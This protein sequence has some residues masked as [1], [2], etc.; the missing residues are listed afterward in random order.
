[1]TYRWDLVRG[2][3]FGVL[4]M[5]VQSFAILVAIRVFDT[6]DMVKPFVPAAYF[7]GYMLTPMIVWGARRAGCRMSICVALC[8]LLG[9]AM[10]GAASISTDRD[11]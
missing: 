3:L 5:I 11:T 6:P 7:V 8:Y 9:G 2:G 10:L 1:M 4:D